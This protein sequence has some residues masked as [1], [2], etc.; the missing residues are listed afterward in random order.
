LDEAENLEAVRDEI[1]SALNAQSFKVFRGSDVGN[2]GPEFRWKDPKDW[3]GFLDLAQQEQIR[4]IICDEKAFDKSEL[5]E[6]LASLPEEATKSAIGTENLRKL[7]SAAGK[8][9][10]VN[11]YWVKDGVKYSLHRTTKWFD[12][13][14]EFA[15]Q[16]ESMGEKEG[17]EESRFPVGGL[18][19][20]PLPKS[21]KSRSPEDLAREMIEFGKKELG[22]LDLRSFYQASRLFWQKIGVPDFGDSETEL[23]KE[24]VR[25]IAEASLTEELQKSERELLPKLVEECAGWADKYGLSKLTKQNLKAFLAEKN[26][27]L[28]RN[29]EDIMLVQVNAK[30]K[31]G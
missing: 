28:T 5:G 22:S 4:I 20:A 24:K 23:L 6:L 25:K 8:V 1:L 9:G 26:Q 3:K 18:M 29:S 31:G 2:G 16:L 11:L 17:P 15:E 7:Q 27:P 19:R 14:A 10:A 12:D 30:L 21:V 13:L